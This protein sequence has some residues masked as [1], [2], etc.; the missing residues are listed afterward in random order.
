MAQKRRCVSACV[1]V[2]TREWEKPPNW[3]S[4]STGTNSLC[5]S[6]TSSCYRAEEVW[7]QQQLSKAMSKE[8][9]LQIPGCPGR[10]SKSSIK[11]RG[12]LDQ[13]I[14]LKRA[15]QRV[16]RC[17]KDK[18]ILLCFDLKA[19]SPSLVSFA[20]RAQQLWVNTGWF[21]LIKQMCLHSHLVF[22]TR[23]ETRTH[24]V[25]SR[26]GQLFLLSE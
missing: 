1:C 25:M 12:S 11:V 16:E 6:L 8:C 9:W 2:R 13:V 23:A 15:S 7:G 22:G 21:L 24:A 3:E 4:V 5:Y 14:R 17:T 10:C 19:S 26:I 18:S 20:C